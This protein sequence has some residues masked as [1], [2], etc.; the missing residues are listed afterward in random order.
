MIQS[1]FRI[2]TNLSDSLQLQQDIDSLRLVKWSSEWNLMFDPSKTVQLSFKS[3][4]SSTYTIETSS[5]T[6]VANHCDLGVIV[7]IFRFPVGTP[8]STYYLQ[9]LAHKML[10][11][12]RHTFSVYIPITS[13]KQLYISLI[14][15]LF[16][17]CSVLWKR[18]LIKHIQLLKHI[19]RRATKY[20]L[21]NS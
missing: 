2:I 9:G 20:I 16:M 4:E 14:Q 11:L 18:Y 3:N 1:T 12:L 19:Q 15:S 17:Y 10:G 13:I 6:K 21:N 7:R 8:L 5:I